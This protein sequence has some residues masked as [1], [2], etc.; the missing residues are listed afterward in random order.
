M[1]KAILGG[2]LA[3]APVTNFVVVYDKKPSAGGY[4]NREKEGFG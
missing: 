3:Y 1:S 4:A 2:T